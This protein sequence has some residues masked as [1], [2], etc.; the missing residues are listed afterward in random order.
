MFRYHASVNSVQL[1]NRNVRS[2]FEDNTQ[3][4]LIVP[5][6][7]K[8]DAQTVRTSEGTYDEGARFNEARKVVEK[9]TLNVFAR[10]YDINI[11]DHDHS[12]YG[13]W[14][15]CCPAHLS[16][17]GPRAVAGATTLHC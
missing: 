3:A 4:G 11:V 2:H 17:A 12:L 6:W 10:K 9:R 16:A 13:P 8:S 1:S 14:P 7:L 5:L 15:A